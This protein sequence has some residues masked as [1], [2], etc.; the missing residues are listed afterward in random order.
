MTKNFNGNLSSQRE[1]SF[2][3]LL[4]DKIVSDEKYL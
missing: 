1:E 3:V 2:S 4:N